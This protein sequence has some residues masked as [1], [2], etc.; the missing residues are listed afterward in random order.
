MKRSIFVLSLLLM[1]S[2][3]WSQG[4]VWTSGGESG[5]LGVRLRD[6]SADD[7]KQL[8][9][10]S[11]TGAVVAE[12]TP[13]SPAAEAGLIDG[14][15]IVEV[16]GLPILSARHLQRVIADNPPDRTLTLGIIRAGN[17]QS[18]PVKLGERRGGR[19]FEMPR[20][21]AP[22]LEKEDGPH[23]FRFR[24]E[25]PEIRIFRQGPRLGIEGHAVSSDLAQAL[26]LAT[27]KGVLVLTVLPDSAADRAGVKA[28]DVIV[29][30]S[31]V[32]I[33]S[34]DALRENLKEGK[35]DLEVER[36][37]RRLHLSVDLNRE[38]RPGVRL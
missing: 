15:V 3:V 28:G 21:E 9:L 12:V 1:A 19:A 24:G 32:A 36:S 30:V 10:P 23:V 27:D 4:F 17:R 5:Y 35:V 33:E 26:N 11:E 6:V 20:L 2:P 22:P 16:A 14:D 34:L 13:D 31:G 8:R 29:A 18:L 7:A 25:G 38:E 37:G